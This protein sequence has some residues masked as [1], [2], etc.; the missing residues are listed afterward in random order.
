MCLLH[1]TSRFRKL[2]LYWVWTGVGRPAPRR[3]E[4]SDATTT[5]TRRKQR[6]Q[7]ELVTGQGALYESDR[8]SLYESDRTGGQVGTGPRDARAPFIDTGGYGARYQPARGNRRHRLSQVGRSLA[9]GEARI[10]R[11]R[12]SDHRR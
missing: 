5:A 9:R 8:G 11:P 10:D 6:H 2:V 1:G 3:D 4:S 12:R 7:T